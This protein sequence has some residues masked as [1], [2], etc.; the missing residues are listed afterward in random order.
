VIYIEPLVELGLSISLIW[1][2]NK[3]RLAIWDHFL[4]AR[5][6]ALL[7]RSQLRAMTSPKSHKADEMSPEMDELQAGMIEI[8]ASANGQMGTVENYLTATNPQ[9]T[10]ADEK[11]RLRWE[12]VAWSFGVNVWSD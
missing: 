7:R 2:L 6:A 3:W 8:I 4:L 11:V 12:F 10:A 9:P 1:L 5:K